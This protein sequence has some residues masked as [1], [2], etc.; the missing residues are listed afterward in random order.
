MRAVVP[1]DLQRPAALDRRPRAVGDHRDATERLEEMRRLERVE[2]NGLLHALHRQRRFVVHASR[3]A[4]EHGR[5]F[6]G[7][8]D[9]PIAI[10]VEPELRLAGDDVLLVVG[11][12]VLANHP[13]RGL[14][15]EL[16]VFRLRHRELRSRG[17]Q[18][19]K[20]QSPVARFMNHFVIPHDTLRR[21]HVPL[22]RRRTHQHRP[23]GRAGAAEGFVEVAHGPRAVG[24]LIAVAG[25]ADALLD[26]A[27]AP[28][29]VELVGGDH[30][31]RGADAGAHL[32]SV[33]DDE[34]RAVGLDAEIDTRIE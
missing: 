14:R 16:E 27:A 2:R 20:P 25:V 22:R 12:R 9:H 29:G 17:H 4:T 34:D 23:C 10:D 1:V 3:R 31:Q 13:P 15:L 26:A 7:G 28:V 5:V 19:A 6:D 21:G 11:G 8:V 30:R 18:R 32:R 33:R 24:V